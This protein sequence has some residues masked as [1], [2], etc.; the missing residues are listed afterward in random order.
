MSGAATVIC[1]RP[2]AYSFMLAVVARMQP[3]A[4]VTL[5]FSSGI[6]LHLTEIDDL[7]RMGQLQPAS[8]K[9]VKAT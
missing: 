7:I 4:D 5:P 2:F 6:P 8:I 9:G 3:R 1:R